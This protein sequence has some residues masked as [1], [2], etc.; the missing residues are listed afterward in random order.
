MT[1]ALQTDVVDGATRES[2]AAVPCVLVIGNFDGVHKGHQAVL[3]QA[4]HEARAQGLVAC[5]LTFHPHPAEVVGAGAPPLLTSMRDRAVL[6]ASLGVDRVYVRRFDRSFAAWSPERFAVD[7][8][9]GTIAAR[10]VVVGQ[11]FRFGA[12]RSGDLDRLRALGREHGFEVRVAA[13]ASDENGPYSSTRVR[14][15]LAAGD[16]QEASAVL[17]RA[18][19]LSGVVVHGDARG[20]ELGFP[21]ANLANIVEV[22]PADGIYAVTVERRDDAGAALPLGEG[23]RPVQGVMSIGIRPTIG[24]SHRTVEVYLLGFAGDLYGANLRVA[25]IARLRDE[26]K[27]ASLDDLKAQIARDVVD[28]QSVLER[29]AP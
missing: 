11:D 25:L 15:A 3:R 12:K 5:A 18:H 17:G 2:L 29:E 16:L 22:L 20:R 13:V 10:A 23:A 21:T 28:A 26:K 27:F 9:A 19:S 7:L 14:D 6:M 1:P 24:T 8:V 4:V